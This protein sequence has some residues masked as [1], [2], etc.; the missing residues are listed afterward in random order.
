MDDVYEDIDGYSQSR[1]R[2]VPIFFFYDMI[3]DSMTNKK[4]KA[5]IKEL[6]SR[7]RKLYISLAFIS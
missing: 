7:S 1:Q 3:A 2:N 6:F 5:I 4:F